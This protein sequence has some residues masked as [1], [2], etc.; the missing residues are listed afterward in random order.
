ML[1]TGLIYFLTGAAGFL[2]WGQQVCGDVLSNM[3]IDGVTDILWGHVPLAM[4][5]VTTVKARGGAAAGL[6]SRAALHS[7]VAQQGRL[8][9]RSLCPH[10]LLPTLPCCHPGVNG[11][12]AGSVLPHHAVADAAGYHRQAWP[13]ATGGIRLLGARVQACPPF[14]PV[15]SPA[16]TACTSRPLLTMSTVP[17]CR[18][19]GRH[20]WRAPAVACR[21]LHADLPVAAAHLPAG[22]LHLL[23]IPGWR[24]DSGPRHTTQ[25]AAPFAPMV[26]KLALG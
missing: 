14:V 5:F 11:T 25:A 23:S 9:S 12:V 21:I 19:P 26:L 18:D 13:G 8:L 10:C 16:S 2:V 4:A 7:G 17:A 3:T 1:A 22:H 20:V 24:H 6:A 15:V